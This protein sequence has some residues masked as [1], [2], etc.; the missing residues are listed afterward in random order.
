LTRRIRPS[1]SAST[2]AFGAAST[3]IRRM[4][5]EGRLGSCI[6]SLERISEAPSQKQWRFALQW[7]FGG[8]PR[9]SQNWGVCEDR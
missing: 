8:P 7:V 2:I 3:S 6:V 9:A 5:P 4:R 1:A